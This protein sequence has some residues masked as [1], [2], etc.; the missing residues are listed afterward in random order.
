AVG[1]LVPDVGHMQEGRALESDVDEGRL[2][3]RKYAH[4][5]AEI[6]VSDDAAV[7]R[8][9]DVQLLHHTL[10]GDGHTRFLRRAVDEEFDAHAWCPMGNSQGATCAPCEWLIERHSKYRQA[11]ACKQLCSLEQGQT[12][13]TAV[14]TADVRDED[15]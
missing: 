6:D 5:A 10:L 2:H 14:A 11:E 9:F 15:R 7:G 3:A 4:D 8:A 12:H 13:D 1:A